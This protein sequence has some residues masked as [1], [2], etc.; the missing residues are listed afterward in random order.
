MTKISCSEDAKGV[1]HFIYDEVFTFED[2][3]TIQP[4]HLAYETYGKLSEAKDNVILIHHALSTNSHVASHEN[5]P[6]P[7]WWENMLG[8]NKPIDS[9]KYFIICISNI[10]S[11]FES[12]GPLSINPKTEKSYQSTFP[13]TSITDIVKSQH[14]LLEY[15]GINKLYAILGNSV[16]A[17]LSITWAVLYPDEVNKLVSTS[18]C[19]KSYPTNAENRA[20]QRETIL[21]DPE[22]G[23]GLYEEQPSRGF[24]L[25]RKH[26]LLT[27]R[28]WEELNERFVDKENKESL[29]NY[30]QYNAEKFIKRFDLNAY[31]YQLAMMD[32]FNITKYFPS[33]L[34][35]FQ[36]INADVLVISVNTDVLY[37]P[38]QQHDLYKE[39]SAAGVNT[40]L[41]EHIS[42]I[43]HDAFLVETPAFGCYLTDF[44]G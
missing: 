14:L 8:P 19:Y 37:T 24:L 17:M 7:G 12:S 44:L 9:N 25:A 22:Y 2:G 29:A 30:L 6:Q 11:C 35:T 3:E 5:N 32:S 18:S 23:D 39:L 40:Q 15:L 41:I 1:K 33:N 13:E 36:R 26:A 21:L 31:L 38:D 43:G 34:E 27:Y 16:G 20:L 10:A 42:E 28:N 4:L